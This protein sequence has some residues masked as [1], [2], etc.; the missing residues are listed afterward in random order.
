MDA[1]RIELKM[2]PDLANIFI[3]NKSRKHFPPL[4]ERTI[5]TRQDGHRKKSHLDPISLAD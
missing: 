2:V 1:C 3:L 5:M 4:D